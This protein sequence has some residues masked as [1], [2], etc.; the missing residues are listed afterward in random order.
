MSYLPLIH[1]I[2]LLT[3][4]SFIQALLTRAFRRH[5]LAHQLISGCLFGLVTV[6]GMMAPMPLV[7]GVFFDGR[8][9]VLGVAGLFGGPVVGAVAALLGGGYRL[10]LGGAGALMGA[11]VVASSTLLGICGHYLWRRDFQSSRA[12]RLFGLGVL[13]HGAMLALMGLL[14]GGLGWHALLKVGLP[15]LLIY[16]PAFTL[17]GLFFVEIE[18]RIRAERT[19]KESE[20]RF[21]SF[22]ENANDVVASLSPEGIFSYVSPHWT[23]VMGCGA[24]ATI[25]RSLF[26]AFMHPGDAGRVRAILG[27]VAISGAKQGG[28]EYRM[29]HQDGSE[30]WHVA[31]LS[32]IRQAYGQAQSILVIATDITEKKRAEAERRELSAQLH[33]AQKLESLGA[34]AGGVAHDINNVLAAVLGLASAHREAMEESHPMAKALD[35]I[36]SACQRGRGVVKGL[37][38]F[39]RKDLETRGEVD[40][41]AVI[42]ELVQLLDST[43]LKRI[44]ITMDLQ[45]PLEPVDGDAGALSHALMNLCVNALDAMPGGG[46]LAIRTRRTQDGS[47]EVRVKD[48]GEGMSPDVL[49]KAVEPFFTTKPLGKGTGLGLAM[50]YGTVRAH[51]GNINIESRL[52]EGTE[53][54]IQ[55]PL[56]QPGPPSSIPAG[57][58]TDQPR[59][60][61]PRRILLVDDDEL[62]RMSV[63]PM[64]EMLG[65][66][67]ET[68][69]GGREA[70]ARFEAG[71]DMDLVIL[72]M[73]MPDLDGTETLARLRL[74]RP[75]QP[76]LL[77]SG[78]NDQDIAGLLEGQQA[79]DSIRKP[80]TLEELQHKLAA[81]ET[82]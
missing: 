10:W 43:T 81:M 59:A 64:L 3:C 17:V 7:P 29:R 69:S 1:N 37:L 27:Q 9:I 28:I 73:N 65:H 21:R 51:Q 67:V 39:A 20:E 41:N 33:Q 74:L 36:S 45:R 66:D 63:G 55:L 25:G 70:L 5:S 47:I 50:V 24:K 79:I 31:N 23:E 2:A 15:V 48:A 82:A 34:L 76:V 56:A 12:S 61:G 49:K 13:I 30:R 18:S 14:P 46:A 42:E 57:P 8:S 54:T 35:T 60:V 72:D 53:V 52:G 71:Q 78:Y 38:Y 80:F 75:C 22:V 58:C 68:A 40:L 32:P 6:A 4:L 44:Q 11:S 62:I 77:C 26:D 16:P 19:L